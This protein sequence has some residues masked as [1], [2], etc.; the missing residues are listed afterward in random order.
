MLYTFFLITRQHSKK[1]L[2]Y[3]KS[4]IVEKIHFVYIS[5]ILTNALLFKN[6]KYFIIICIN[7]I[8]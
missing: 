2:P 3:A 5:K 8:I 1:K 6:E 4:L 7:F